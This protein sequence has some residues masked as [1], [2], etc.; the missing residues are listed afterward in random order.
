MTTLRD[1]AVMLRAVEPED[2]EVMSLLENDA[3]LWECSNSTV[4]YS[5]HVLRE[6][7]KQCS[8]N[9]FEDKAVRLA[10]ALP[11]GIAVG[12][13]DLQNYDHQ[14]QRAEV[15]IVLMRECQ[16]LGLARRA[17]RLLTDYSR[18]VLHL[19]QVYA[20]V[21]STNRPALRLFRAAGFTHTAT[22]PQW[23]R[24]VAGWC[25]VEVFQMMLEA[26]CG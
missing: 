5:S 4:P 26:P 20:H 24:C 2:L 23:T 1:E 3:S 17:L 12:F 25:D 9:F 19:H 22:L 11:E 13:I 6:Y 16:H 18:S 8:Y 21:Q 15:G 7:I 10:I 14:H